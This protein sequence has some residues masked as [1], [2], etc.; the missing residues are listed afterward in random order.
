MDFKTIEN[1]DVQSWLNIFEAAPQ[2]FCEKYGIS[3][4]KIEGISVITCQKI[5]FPHFNQPVTLGINK[6]FN[7][8]TL[9]AVLDWFKKRDIQKF[10]IHYTPATE[11]QE[12]EAWFLARNLRFVNAWDRIIRDDTPLSKK[13]IPSDFIV[14]DVTKDNAVEW[15]SFIDVVYGMPTSEWL[16]TLVGLDSWHHAI[17]KENGKIVAARS[18]H[19][20]ADKTAYMMID[21]PVPGIMTQQFEPDFYVAQRLVEIGL[22]SGVE[23]FASDIEKPSP[24]HD[25]IAYNLWRQLGFK[26]AYLKKNYMY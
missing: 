22:A 3:V 17:C 24:T 8:K 11:P 1:A 7:E 26:V 23:L 12:S 15:A 18:L 14:E 10:Y 13:P 16:L 20:N 9:D 4:D 5:P 6:P 19:I 25:T 21:A 2:S